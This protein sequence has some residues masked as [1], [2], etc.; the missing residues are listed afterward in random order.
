MVKSIIKYKIFN[1][2]FDFEDWQ[3][4]NKDIVLIHSIV[5]VATDTIEKVESRSFSYSISVFVTYSMKESG[6]KVTKKTL[7][8][9]K[10]LIERL[11]YFRSLGS[12]W[13]VEDE[14]VIKDAELW[15]VENK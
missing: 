9:I 7:S 15:I 10:K 4:E 8:L 5:P 12:D 3:R 14:I 13:S 2:S 6:H 1:S 11:D